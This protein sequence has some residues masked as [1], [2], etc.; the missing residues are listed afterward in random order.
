M[1]YLLISDSL[2]PD[3]SLKDVLIFITGASAI[4]PLGFQPNPKMRFVNWECLPFAS[5]CDNVINF[6]CTLRN[7]DTFKNKFIFALCGS[8]GFGNV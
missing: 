6:P 4:P 5:S 1:Y 8:H 3:V 7:Y 2:V